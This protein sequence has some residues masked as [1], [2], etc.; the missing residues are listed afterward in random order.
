LLNQLL[1]S[2]QFKPEHY[3]LTNIVK[4][5]PPLN[6]IPTKNE[7]ESCLPYLRHEFSML[8]PKIVVCLGELA[9]KYLRIDEA[10]G[11]WQQKNN[12]LFLKTYHPATLLHDDAKKIELWQDMKNV[13]NKLMEIIKEPKEYRFE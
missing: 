4:C 11:V 1:I 7:S 10:R 8:N 13:R 2:L 6:R 12:T 9:S 3:Y 5:H